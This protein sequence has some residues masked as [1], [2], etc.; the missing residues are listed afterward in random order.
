MTHGTQAHITEDQISLI[1]DGVGDV[2]LQEHIA[3]CSEC[4]RRVEEARQLETALHQWLFRQDCPSPHKLVDYFAGIVSIEDR[5]IIDA[6]LSI[7][8]SCR[9]ELETLKRFMEDRDQHPATGPE[10]GKMMHSPSNFFVA[11]VE[12]RQTNRHVRGTKRGKEK[13]QLRAQT[14]G[15][16]VLLDFQ[17]AASGIAV[18][19]TVIDIDDSRN[20]VGSLVEFRKEDVLHTTCL[21]DE[22]G[23][24]H[25]QLSDSGNYQI[26]IAAPDGVM[27]VVPDITIDT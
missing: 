16:V 21:V 9:E 15:I 3:G 25:C 17:A 24:F 1:L 7:C 5:K 19:G 11:R 23:T 8:V 6:H 14:D 18:E 12:T 10:K 22:L 20:W 26:R 2:A 13:R 27:V 4:Q